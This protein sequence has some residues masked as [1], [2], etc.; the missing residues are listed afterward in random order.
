MVDLDIELSGVQISLEVP[1][2]HAAVLLLF[3]EKGKPIF[4][5]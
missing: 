3:L 1:L 2:G 4:V 5:T